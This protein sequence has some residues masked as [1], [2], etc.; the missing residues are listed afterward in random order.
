MSYRHD[1]KLLC[2]GCEPPKFL[3]QYLATVTGRN[4]VSSSNFLLDVLEGRGMQW[5]AV[6]ALGHLSRIRTSIVLYNVTHL[7][8]SADWARRGRGG[9]IV[10]RWLTTT[11]LSSLAE[12]TS[13]RL[14]EVQSHVSY[15]AV[16]LR[17]NLRW[18]EQLIYLYWCV[19][20]YAVVW[21]SFT[22][23]K[24]NLICDLAQLSHRLAKAAEVATKVAARRGHLLFPTVDARR[25]RSQFPGK[26]RG[27]LRP[28]PKHW[29]PGTP[30]VSLVLELFRFLIPAKYVCTSMQCKVAIQKQL[31][32][33]PIT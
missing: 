6:H 30:D 5:N 2:N 1:Q 29:T 12:L 7:V 27:R 33:S 10:L 13:G 11:R 16:K 17:A 24:T 26:R 14:S 19:T 18:I 20:R 21:S 22:S 4:W 31:G 15:P 32:Q 8:G 23:S 28:R 9:P 25:L 3:V